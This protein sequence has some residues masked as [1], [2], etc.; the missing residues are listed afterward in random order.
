MREAGYEWDAERK[1]LRKI[2]QKPE[3]SYC[4]EHCKGYKESG[5]KCYFGFD[6]EAKREAEKQPT[7]S[8]EDK[9]FITAIIAALSLFAKEKDAEGYFDMEITWLKSLKDRIQPRPKQEWSEEEQQIIKDAASFILACVNT[10]ETK[11]EEERL[12]KLA[13]KLQDLRPRNYTYK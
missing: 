8:E 6:C 7:W 10:A 3:H 5:G 2:E 12:E 4:Q 9:T 1:E 13:D 11:E